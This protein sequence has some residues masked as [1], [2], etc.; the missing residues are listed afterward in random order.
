MTLK[1]FIK[2]EREAL[3]IEIS[4]RLKKYPYEKFND[5]ERRLWILN[6]ESLYSW[7]RSHGVRI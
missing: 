2:S 3:D 4:K 5:H 6:D 1:E 7:A